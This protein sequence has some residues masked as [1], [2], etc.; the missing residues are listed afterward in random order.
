MSN[1]IMR[2]LALVLS[3][4]SALAYTIS[5]PK[6]SSSTTALSSYYGM[7]PYRGGYSR[8]RGYYDR[9][10]DGR[11]WNRYGADDMYGDYYNRRGMNRYRY[12]EF[13]FAGVQMF[14]FNLYLNLTI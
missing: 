11:Y 1:F 6:T 9:Y 7:D 12:F 4:S 10:D 5:T 3:I 13:K 2:L 8:G 14:F